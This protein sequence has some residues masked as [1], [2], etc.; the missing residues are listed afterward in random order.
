M[1]VPIQFLWLALGVLVIL[2]P[3]TVYLAT[4][5]LR[6][7]QV[8]LWCAGSL[9]MGIGFVLVSSRGH[10]ATWLSFN[11][12][13]LLVICGYVVRTYSLRTDLPETASTAKSII[14]RYVW[15]LSVYYAAYCWMVYVDLAESLRLTAV[16]SFQ[17]YLSADLYIVS[18]RAYKNVPISGATLIT[19][20]AILLLGTT[21]MKV[22]TLLMGIGSTAVFEVH[23]DQYV[24]FSSY[25]LSYVFGSF[26]FVQLKMY[27][28][29][30]VKEKALQKNIELE[31][32]L[33]E[34]NRLL[35]ELSLSSRANVLG[36]MVVAIIH[37]ISQPLTAMRIQMQ[38]IKRSVTSA[39]E[40]QLSK[41]TNSVLEGIARC[42]EIIKSL[43]G[44]FSKEGAEMSRLN[45]SAL[46][47]EV[48]VI[49]SAEAKL[50]KVNIELDAQ[51]DI[52]VLGEK[53]QLQTVFLN[54]I[55]NAFEAMREAEAG[56]RLG[57]ALRKDKNEVIC[58]ISDTGAGIKQEQLASIFEL[59]S[60][61]K[62]EG[63]GMGLWLSKNIL[64][65]HGATIEAESL[66]AGGA[67]FI[68]AFQ[69]IP[70]G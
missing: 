17:V 11:L 21:V 19:Y 69:G 43:R 16:Y 57:I 27:K 39:A 29:H 48:V 23:V 52:Y 66:Y 38:L 2:L 44:L 33:K 30:S 25:F 8:Y 1:T 40:H 20:M 70:E 12:S 10:I 47:R 64:E 65:V 32:I 58:E 24:A 15:I 49:V 7:L 53:H 14:R 26:G 56:R 36:T 62:T 31:E 46:L 59:Y 37:E 4:S 45:L 35:R 60:T 42:D 13:Q 9:A 51:N 55:H 54:L 18:R 22:C 5:G 67:K 3:L 28:I 34:K 41:S 61:S 63:M 6:D 50:R 68:L